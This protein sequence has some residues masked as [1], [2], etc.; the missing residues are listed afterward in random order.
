MRKKTF[1]SLLIISAVLFLIC[2]I[3]GL[4]YVDEYTNRRINLILTALSTFVTILTL[5][6]AFIPKSK[7]AG[8]VSCWNSYPPLFVTEGNSQIE[9]LK[10]T[11][12]IKNT[13]GSLNNVQIIFRLPNY[14]VNPL[15]SYQEQGI[16]TKVI[17]ETMLTS[18]AT[19]IFLGS[20]YGDDTYII[21]HYICIQKWEKGNIYLTIS[22]DEI[23]TTTISFK[24]DMKS[25]IVK[26]NSKDVIY[27]K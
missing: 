4:V 26:S 6:F 5:L 16:T 2:L 25:L 8:K 22:A 27:L 1:F 19:P 10:I 17:K 18:L 20:S 3:V 24:N 12:C 14:V 11:F 13:K 9:Y 7:F 15:F 21:E 23:E